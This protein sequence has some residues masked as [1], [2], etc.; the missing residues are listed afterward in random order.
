MGH[1]KRPTNYAV[2]GSAFGI[3]IADMNSDGKTDVTVAT[4]SGFSVLLGN[5]DGTFTLGATVPLNLD[6][7][8]IASAAFKTGGLPGVAV[9][10]LTSVL[11]FLQGSLPVLSLAPT[12]LN[13]GPQAPGT[14]SSA[15]TVTLTNTGTATLTLSGIAISGVNATS[16]SESNNC[17]PTLTA[18]ASCQIKVTSTPNAAGAQTASLN[19]KDNAPGSPQTL[20]LNG[21]GSDFSLG[22]SSQT[23]ITVTPGQA[24]NYA[25][26]VSSVSG[27]NQT[28]DLSCS[29]IPPQS[30]CTVTP[31]S[32]A[33]G[34]TA[35]VAVVT[36]TGSA[37][38]TQPAGGPAT[39]NPFGLWAAFSG[40]LGMALLLRMARCRRE[41]RPQF[42]YGLMFLC[43]LSINVATSACGGGS[44]G[45][46][47]GTPMGTY[48]P[49][50]TGTFTAGSAKLVHTAN[51]TLVVR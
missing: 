21:T 37:G 32:I 26:V 30:T 34:S 27:F 20:A 44:G 2:G 35:N 6:Q 49:V 1:L 4:S 25:V 17:P 14:T 9:S 48:N 42:R 41:W 46:S 43:L 16:F 47:G 22:V 39:S 40:A 33:P 50:V 5:G 38:P 12:V 45:G 19:V 7:P 3:A 18:N 29:G 23:S 24:A 36:T 13:F 11:V 15:Q 31:S 28:V 8:S 51:L 10:T